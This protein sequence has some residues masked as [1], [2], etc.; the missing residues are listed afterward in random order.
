[1]TF[2][3]TILVLCFGSVLIADDTVPK[4]RGHEPAAAWR[5]AAAEHIEKIRKGDL[6]IR[7][8]DENGVPVADATVEVRMKRHA[9]GWGSAVAA[10]RLLQQDADGDRYREIVERC[11][12]RVVFENDLKFWMWENPQNREKVF[13]A[14]DW[15]RERGIEIRGHCL[16][17]PS[18]KNSPKRLKE[19]AEEPE[20]I[21]DYFRNHIR[22]EVT[23]MRGRLVD[24]DVVNEPYDNNDITKL[25]GG[26]ASI[27][28]WF[29]LARESDPTAR[30]YLNDYGILSA[31]GRD[32]SHHDSLESL[33]R[34]LIENKVPLNGI[35]LQSHFAEETTPPER[36]LEILDRFGKLGLPITIT[37]HDIDNKDEALQADFTRDFL[38]TV[39]SHPSVDAVLTWG[40]WER[41][42]WRP[43]GAYYRSDWSLKPAGQVW[44]DLVMRD[45]W[46]NSDAKTNADGVATVRGFLGDYTITVS[47][48]DKRKTIECSL[49]KTGTQIEVVIAP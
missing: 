13:A 16:V 38:T 11:F 14:S 18:W 6:Q 36:M 5:D 1:M 34:F 26:D 45:W 41:A 9:F 44:L 15:L 42:H 48:G 8:I 29:R 12:N 37:E 20:K 4:Y 31:E 10:N 21:R 47:R 22:D 35:G 39:F 40:F 27:A 25:L 28:D 24:W 46:T 7:V 2:I 43:A 3:I 30:L 23:A 17:W 33:L 49:P 19:F 32:T